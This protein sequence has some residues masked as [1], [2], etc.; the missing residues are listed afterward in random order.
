V[1]RPRT[2]SARLSRAVRMRTGTSF[3]VARRRV[4]TSQPL[5]P[6][7]LRSRMTAS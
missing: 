4:S 7:R 1:S 3:F 6:G 5:N 2:R